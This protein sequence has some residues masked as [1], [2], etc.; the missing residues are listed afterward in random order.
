M[1]A[2]GPKAAAE[3]VGLP[4]A[5]VHIKGAGMNLHDWR[6]A[7]AVLL[8]Q[9]VGGGSGWPGPGVD[10]WAPEP[11]AGYPQM[12]NPLSSFRKAEEVAKTSILKMWDD[13]HGTCWF[14]TWGVPGQLEYS[15]GAVAATVG[16]DDFTPQEALAVGHRVL[17]LERIFNMARGLTAEDDLNVSPRITDPAPADAGPAAGKSIAPYIE[18]WV[19][20]Y[21]QEVGWERKTGRPMRSTLKKLGL[22]E[23]TD[24]VWGER[25][26][27]PT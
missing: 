23:F 27:R 26:T 1:L 24:L 6:R 7:W 20:D 10:C 3:R 16:W 8:G 14:A 18:G 19:R 17:T 11:D 13:S 15:A 21:Y 12:T 5:A 9:V 4:Q 25:G 22:A 2:D